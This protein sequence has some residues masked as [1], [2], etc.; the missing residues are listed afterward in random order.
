ML[1]GRYLT[2]A[3]NRQAAQGIAYRSEG[4]GDMDMAIEG[5]SCRLTGAALGSS[6]E[7]T[8]AHGI[9]SYIHGPCPDERVKQDLAKIIETPTSVLRSENERAWRRLWASALAF[10]H[11]NPSITKTI[12]A[13]QFYM[14]CSLGTETLPHGALGLS[15]NNWRGSQL[16]DADFWN[17]RGILPLWPELAAPIVRYRRKF[18]PEAQAY[19]ASQGYR[20]AWF[21]WM[22]DDDGRDVTNP[23]YRNEIHLS[24]WI[25]LAAWE[26]FA[27]TGDREFLGEVTWPLVREITEFYCSWVTED[28]DGCFH[29]RN[30]VGP[31]EALTEFWQGVCDDHFMTA[32]CIQKLIKIAADCAQTVGE[33]LPSHWTRVAQHLFLPVGG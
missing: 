31:D 3:Q 33:A 22:T 10:E 28:E 4:F 32:W 14:L 26:Y 27:A 19:A 6:V 13:H 24:F 21:P 23:R 1:V 2:R 15:A 5:H 25:A 29:V 16:W 30:V 11:R 17:F 20:G 9:H 18:L 12:L 8:I 7:L